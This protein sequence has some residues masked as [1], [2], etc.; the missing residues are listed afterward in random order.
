[1]VQKAGGCLNC[2]LHLLLSSLLLWFQWKEK[3]M[4]FHGLDLHKKPEIWH[5]CWNNILGYGTCCL[6]NSRK[7]TRLCISFFMVRNTNYSI[8]PLLCRGP[9]GS[10]QSIRHLNLI[11]VCKKF[12]N[13]VLNF[14]RVYLPYPGVHVFIQASNLQVTSSFSALIG[15]VSSIEWASVP[16]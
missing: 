2:S 3:L 9:P 5:V 13:M 14:Q 8:C 4:T 6:H 16:V 15:T 7:P 1:M 11:M 10:S 12:T